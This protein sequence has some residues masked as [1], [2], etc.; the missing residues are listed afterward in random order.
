MLKPLFNAALLCSAF[1]SASALA[2]VHITDA[3]LRA[4]PPGAPNTAAFMTLHNDGDQA[5]VLVEVKVSQLA[6]KS[7]ELHE[8][9]IQDGTMQM[10]QLQALEIPAKGEVTLQP[11][12]L[13]VMLI[14]LQEA[15]SQPQY[16]FTLVW[17][18]G[19]QQ[20]VLVPV[21]EINKAEHSHS[22]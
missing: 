7:I 14:G 9:S 19:D 12:G 22:H 18:S 3:A 13:H 20:S 16:E 2:E 8:S 1:L 6:V 21:K 11:G 10:R 4:I 17:A 15:L 5:Q